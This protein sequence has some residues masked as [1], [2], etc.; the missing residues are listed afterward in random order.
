MRQWGHV[1]LLGAVLA[2]GAWFSLRDL[3]FFSPD[4]GLRYLQARTFQQYGW[5]QAAIPYHGLRFD[6][7]MRFVPYYYAYTPF[8][9]SLLLA[10]SP[11]FPLAVAAMLNLFG[12]AGI[13]VMPVIGTLLAAGAVTGL[14]S[15]SGERPTP[16]ILWGTVLA[17]PL[18]FYTMTLW[19]HTVGVGLTTLAVYLAARGLNGQQRRWAF[20]AGLAAALA[21]AQRVDAAP[22]AAALGVSLFAFARPHVRTLTL[23]GM[24]GAFG[25]LLT[26][27]LNQMWVGHPLGIV[28]ARQ[29]LGYGRAA[30]YPI[31]A[32]EGV[33]I[34]RAMAATRLLLNVEGGQVLALLAALLLVTGGVF[35]ALVL[36]LPRLRR[37]LPLFTCLAMVATGTLLG[38]L[39]ARHEAI[40]GLLSTLPLFGLALAYVG[41]EDGS[42]RVYRF[43]FVTA[44]L[45]VL[46]VIAVLPTYG[47]SQWGAR[48]LLPAVPL[49]FFLAISAVVSY[50]RNMTW[51]AARA[52][53]WVA[54]VL[55]LLSL[56]VQLMGVRALLVKKAEQVQ[57]RDGIGALPADFVL[58]NNPF[59][60][61]FMSSLEDKGFFYVESEADVALLAQRMGNGGVERITF[62]LVEALPLTIPERAGNVTLVKEAPLLYR[63][64]LAE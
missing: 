51:G 10:I 31:T 7:G 53:R 56:V 43:V 16:R 40:V 17:T 54:L 55:V 64:E 39:P 23:Y 35:L 8:G 38:L 33:T 63:L 58:T 62:V 41:A 49:L 19:D 45:F 34:T 24:G 47:G 48:Y 4:T 61:S 46:F 1:L 22:L 36:R 44:W 3:T 12:Q 14:W 30:Y 29:Y 11:F 27:P 32:Y 59:L 25:L 20:A 50:Q 6:P 13:A 42:S 57:W 2:V 28:M 9:D 52:L 18:L 37:P 60:A 5:Q 15:L 26:V 21:V